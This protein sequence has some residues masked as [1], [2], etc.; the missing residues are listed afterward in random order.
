MATAHQS[1]LRP[2]TGALPHF[3]DDGVLELELAL[4]AAALHLQGREADIDEPRLRAAIGSQLQDGV[5]LQQI[6]KSCCHLL[7]QAG[8]QGGMAT[9]KLEKALTPL[10]FKPR[11]VAVLSAVL[12]WVRDGALADAPR[13]SPPSSPMRSPPT[14]TSTDGGSRGESSSSNEGE[15]L[16]QEISYN[17][18]QAPPLQGTHVEI[19]RRGCVRAAPTPAPPVAVRKASGT[20]APIESAEESGASSSEIAGQIELARRALTEVARNTETGVWNGQGIDRDVALLQAEEATILAQLALMDAKPSVHVERLRRE[21][22]KLLQLFR[23]VSEDRE[24]ARGTES[25][26]F[27]RK[28]AFLAAWNGRGARKQ[29]ASLPPVSMEDHLLQL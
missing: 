10:G 19:T 8:R 29:Q 9:E 3:S 4:R 11:H 17:P 13:L 22:A 28:V 23:Q 5:T 16:L 7:R 14:C 21:E 18:L 24:R 15:E 27:A 12:Q 20:D 2:L 1:A 26:R 25:E 6:L